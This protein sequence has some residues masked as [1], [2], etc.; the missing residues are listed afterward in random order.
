MAVGIFTDPVDGIRALEA[1]GL[2]A[3]QS[4]TGEAV[5][6]A[7]EDAWATNPTMLLAR[8][9][10]RQVR[11]YQDPILS[12][13]QAQQQFGIDGHLT[14]DQPIAQRH[15]RELQ[16][17]KQAELLRQDIQRRAQ[18]GVLEGAAT[19]GAG[20]LASAA[21]PIGL[22]ASFIPV[23]GQSRYAL[24]LAKAG[25]AWGRAGV[26]LG[27]GALEGAAGA[28][29]LEPLVYGLTQQ[30]QA[31]Y[32]AADS[33]LNIAFGTV[34]GGGLH[35]GIGRIGDGVA[36]ARGMAPGYEHTVDAEVGRRLSGDMTQPDP[37]VREALAAFG[38]DD[39][40]G[41]ER[42]LAAA[43]PDTREALLRAAVAQI[44][45]GR[46]VAVKELA[47]MDPAL[48]GE[49]LDVGRVLDAAQ[50]DPLGP[51]DAALARISA[52]GMEDI[53]FQK[54]E[55]FIDR[56]GD[57]VAEGDFFKSRLPVDASRGA[58]KLLVKHGDFSDK[59]GTPEHLTRADIIALP[60]VIRRYQPVA[61]G[62][63]SWGTDRIMEKRWE[64]RRADGSHV[65][66]IINRGETG[67]MLTA[68]VHV[69]KKG[70]EGRLSEKRSAP[71]AS[72]AGLNAR[73]TADGIAHRPS[74]ASGGTSQQYTQRPRRG[75]GNAGFSLHRPQPVYD[76]D[77][78]RHMVRY[79]LV[80]ASSLIASH[81]DDLR[82]NPSFPAALQPRDR[83]R[84]AAESQIND[85]VANFEP[86]RLGH[87]SD[88][89]TGA[90]II[91]PDDVVES[92][93]GRVLSIRRVLAANGE[94][95]RR[96]RAYLAELGFNPRS[97]RE[98]VL[99][100][101]RLD[102][103]PEDRRRAFTVAAQKAA[104]LELSATERAMADAP[105]LD[106]ILHLLDGGDVTLRRNDRF[107]EAFIAKLPQAEQGRLLAAD[108]T[109]SLDG[110]RRVEA[111]LLARAFDDADLLGRM[112]EADDDNSRAIVGALLD[113]APDWARM[114][115]AA[116][117]GKIPPGLDATDDLLA[118]VRAIRD[119]RAAGRPLAEILA[120]PDF[121]GTRSPETDQ[122]L[123]IMLRDQ[124]E[125]RMRTASR[126]AVAEHLQRYVDEALKANP[127]PDI[128]GAAPPGRA[129]VLAALNRDG[130]ARSDLPPEDA[131]A[132]SMV[133]RLLAEAAPET[134]LDSDD[135]VLDADFARAAEQGLVD[136]A[137]A[138]ITEAEALLRGADDERRGLESAAF[139]LS[140]RA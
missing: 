101:R 28:A 33:M 15:A 110:R 81:G 91:G 13:E 112:L 44:A 114:R 34:L 89:A 77:G 39:A 47:R 66:Y 131:E 32:G 122:F 129:E 67:D 25:G 121:F 132:L 103:L 84:A 46:P 73:D 96:Y 98:P 113:V 120:Q 118:A 108:G 16:E 123:A 29:M 61:G 7:W 126:E 72:T 21:D 78:T 68:T 22:A 30:E 17:L 45:D 49:M 57:I 53:L 93:N 35:A 106:N 109:L 42:A 26:R 20:F 62:D 140:R 107:V 59:T 37:Y 75:Q 83:A 52:Q 54:G 65:R 111:A 38:A 18:G 12:A 23:V 76:A 119:A 99:V 128:F 51:M 63:K 117:A 137:D 133:D 90:P 139:C 116:Q 64:I 69:R 100:R 105:L 97:R 115:A 135:A 136:G 5:G 88:A 138:S 1:Q 134:R 31:D 95:A 60:D 11:D 48:R 127:D 19:L 92:G 24:A 104:T 14:F 3:Y 124:G 9:A 94:D 82:E 2:D 36:A 43:Q 58:V 50:A 70:E 86:E 87:S 80:E 74:E 8:W 10:G 71:L 85:I 6:A 56:N 41:L 125:G 79:E 40:S 4:T 102:D 27:Y 55:A 130:S